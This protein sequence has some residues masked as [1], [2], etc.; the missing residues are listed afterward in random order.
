LGQQESAAPPDI[1]FA[2]P[3]FAILA[4]ETTD[5]P[6]QKSFSPSQKK[7]HCAW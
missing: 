7:K 2:L 6:S 3:E 1:D 4:F 5:L